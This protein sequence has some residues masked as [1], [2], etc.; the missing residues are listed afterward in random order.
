MDVILGRERTQ[1]SQVIKQADVLLLLALL[2]DRF[3]PG[4]REANFRYYTPRCGHGSSLSRSIHALVA[5]RLGDVALAKQQFDETAAIDLQDT[6]RTG[7][8]GVHIAALGGL[9]QAAVFGCA[10][11]SFRQD[12][13]HLDPH[14]P[15]SWRGLRFSIQWRGRCVQVALQQEPP[16]LSVTLEHGSPLTLYA[17]ACSGEVRVGR[18]WTCRREGPDREWK[19]VPV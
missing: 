4:Q 13:L 11:L 2:W 17:G 15:R 1:Q 19:E 16:T 7:A 14:L 5:A 10:G 3:S 9:W 18:S 8:G 6:T 12:G